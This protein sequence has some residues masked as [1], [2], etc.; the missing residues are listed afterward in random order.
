MSFLLVAR[1]FVLMNKEL[2]EANWIERFLLFIGKRKGFLIE[3]NSMLPTLKNGDAVLIAPSAKLSVG[4]IVLA[5]HPFKRSVK[6]IKRIGTIDAQGNYFLLG[7][8]PAESSDS[9]TFGTVSV[10]N[11]LGKAVCRFR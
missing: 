9:R 7:D 6:I 1:P 10:K 8:N 3:G 4:D 5:R 11:I 2:P